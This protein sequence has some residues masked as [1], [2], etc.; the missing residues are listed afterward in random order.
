MAN[1]SLNAAAL[2]VAVLALLELGLLHLGSGLEHRLSDAFVRAQA[3]RLAPDPG[4]VIVDIDEASLARLQDDYG[5]W[6]WPRAIY[7]EMLPGL[8][9][10]NPA[11]VVFDLSFSERDIDRPDS[12]QA[13]ADTL[14]DQ[15]RVYVPSLRLSAQDDA[16]GVLLSEFG[17]PMGARRSAAASDDA[18]AM[19]LPPLVLPPESWR[20][21]LIN[22]DEESDGVGRSY[23]LRLDV[24]GWEFPSLPA[25]VAADLGWQ[26][27]PGKSL[28]LHWRGGA[29]NGYRHVSFADVHADLLRRERQR[30][31]DEFRDRIVIIGSAASMLHDLRVTPLGNRYPGVEVLATAFDNLKHGRSMQ[32]P[33]SW[34]APALALLLIALL[35]LA[36]HRRGHALAIGVVFAAVSA[37]LLA[38][39]W[40]AVPR[41]WLLPVLLPLGFAWAFYFSGALL[42]Y[43]RERRA[44]RQA[45]QLFGRFLNPVVV[46]KL[47][48]RGE[49][50]ESLSG[51]HHQ[52]SV[53]FSDIRGFTSLSETRPP[54]EI[55]E[56]LNRYFSKQVAIV[57]KHGGTLDKFIGDCIM[58]FWGAPIPDERHAQNAVACALDMQQALLEFRE[59]LGAAAAD[60]D[61]GIGIHSGAAVVGFIGAEQKLEYTA[62]GDTVNLA[63]RVEG[64]TKGVARILVSSDTMAACGTQFRFASRGSFKVKG[65]A[66]EVELYEPAYESGT[67]PGKGEIS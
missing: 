5:R 59:E 66:Q 32:R 50:V 21:G 12:D 19:L 17:P 25:R 43:L 63:S 15:P 51:K 46:N 26:V 56:L 7:A 42:E 49:T 14:R 44:R 22:F 24:Q 54:Q 9:A 18:R 6:P 10:Q 62:I 34:A 2:L 38:L 67:E 58:A 11:A 31:A 45:V 13:L 57:F 36:F 65:R 64:L 53:L 20:T 60:F 30:P 8:L 16:R 39:A 27:P 48:E 37:A 61:V 41:L 52:L 55:V 28:L 1:P 40:A 4:I 33:P 47:V 3:A 35:W 23:L 29:D